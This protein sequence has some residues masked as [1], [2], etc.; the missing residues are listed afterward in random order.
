MKFKTV[1]LFLLCT[2]LCTIALEASAAE[3]I[4]KR[5][6]LENGMILLLSERHDIP[7]VTVSMALKAGNTAV[8]QG[9]PGLAAITAS[10]LT[11][12]TGRRSAS[13]ISR[14]IDF[15][16]GSLSV[17]GGDDCLHTIGGSL[18]TIGCFLPELLEQLGE[19]FRPSRGHDITRLIFHPHVKPPNQGRGIRCL[20]GKGKPRKPAI[21]PVKSTG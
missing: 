14:E 18:H 19:D 1:L 9:K 15:I 16:G 8:M 21:F 3:P 17:S 13:Q 4:G 5:I 7:M 20:R 2:V 11:Q 6:Q 12:G 10:L